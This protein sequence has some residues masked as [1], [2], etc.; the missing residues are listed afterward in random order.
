M[1]L[2]SGLQQACSF[3]SQC[4][5]RSPVGFGH[6]SENPP[7]DPR[8]TLRIVNQLAAERYPDA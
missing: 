4:H 5:W 7:R 6:M 8:L 3:W 1:S 2:G